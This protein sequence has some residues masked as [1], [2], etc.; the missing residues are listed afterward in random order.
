[1]ATIQNKDS[2]QLGIGAGTAAGADAAECEV[3]V[4]TAIVVKV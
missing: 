1:M 2:R 3:S 4:F